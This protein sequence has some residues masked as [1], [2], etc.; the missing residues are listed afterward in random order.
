MNGF[1]ETTSLTTDFSIDVS[2][3]TVE[4]CGTFQD[5]GLVKN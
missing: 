1:F 2:K 4:R 3:M 5:Q